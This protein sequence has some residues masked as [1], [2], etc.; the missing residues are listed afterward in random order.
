[1]KNT[2]SLIT[3]FI[4]G[5]VLFTAGFACNTDAG[6]NGEP[7]VASPET[8]TASN[9]VT[10]A[11]K[12]KDIT[13]D[14]EATGTNPNGG[15]GYKADL[16]ITPRG[17]VYQFSWKSGGKSYDGVG[18][19]TDGE[20]AVSY[21]NGTN[22]KGCGVVLYKIGADG[23]LDGRS[24]YW[25]VNT[26]ETEKATRTSGSDLEGSYD[27]TGKN[28]EGKE[29]KGTLKVRKDGDGYTFDWNAGSQFSGFGIKADNFV[30]VGFGGKQCAFVG[31]DIQSDG[32]LAGKWGGQ[33]STKFGTETAKPK[34]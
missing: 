4:V 8:N 10:T 19:M 27:L 17:D 26:M 18:V 7:H 5:A 3:L 24:G 29:Y 33:G 23:S 22:G 1:V 6:K 20:V 32:T 9:T 25:G 34:K 31:Y 30:A 15:G 14:Y 2:N 13:G 28:P 11:A 16:T 21:T 12:P